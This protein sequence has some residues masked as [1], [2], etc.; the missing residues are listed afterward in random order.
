LGGRLA[1]ATSVGDIMREN[2]LRMPLDQRFTCHSQENLSFINF[3]GHVVRA[4]RDIERIRP[5]VESLLGPIN[6]RST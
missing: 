5:Q 1:D 4:C 6:R 2:M 3:A